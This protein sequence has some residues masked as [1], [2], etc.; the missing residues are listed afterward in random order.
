MRK[1]FNKK[2]QNIYEEDEITKISS[3]REKFDLKKI[4]IKRISKIIGLVLVGFILS[5]ITN[6]YSFT[7]EEYEA[8]DKKYTTLKKE[9][10]VLKSNKNTLQSEKEALQSKIDE[11]A[12]WF[13]MKE[14]ERKAEEEKLAKEQAEKEAAEK[15]AQEEAEAKEQAKKEKE[16]KQGYET[17]I[18]YSQLARTPDDYMFKKVKFKGKVIQVMEGTDT[19]QIRLAVNGSYDNILLGE[20]SS[21]IVESRILEDDYITVYGVSA[22]L[23]TYESTMGGN[24]TIPSIAIAKIDG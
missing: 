21:N 9:Y 14:E 20:Y 12:P 1:L 5:T 4:N 22:G 6:P 19:I 2:N 13:E 8:L 3:K 16:E 23:I 11:A 15:K 18:T 10:D 7:S 24:I 17:G